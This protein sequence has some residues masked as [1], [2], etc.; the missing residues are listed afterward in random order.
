MGY[1]ITRAQHDKLE[2]LRATGRLCW[3][4]TGRGGCYARATVRLTYESWNYE[5]DRTAGK[6][7]VIRTAVLCRAHAKPSAGYLDGANFHGLRLET[8]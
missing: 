2:A 7:P 5:Q 3:V 6:A 8:Y 4:S 1:S